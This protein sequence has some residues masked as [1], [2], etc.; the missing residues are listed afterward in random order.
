KDKLRKGTEITVYFKKLKE[1]EVI[2]N[3]Y[4]LDSGQNI[5]LTHKD[6]KEKEYFAGIV[7]VLFGLF[8]LIFGGFMLKKK[9]LKKNWG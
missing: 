8:V 6:Y 2:N 1:T 4:R 3:I 9:G 5:I 7:M